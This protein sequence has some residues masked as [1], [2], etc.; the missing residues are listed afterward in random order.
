[1][2]ISYIYSVRK[3]KYQIYCTVPYKL[4]FFLATS[5]LPTSLVLRQSTQPE[6]DKP[7]HLIALQNPLSSASRLYLIPSQLITSPQSWYSQFCKRSHLLRTRTCFN[8]SPL[9][10]YGNMTSLCFKTPAL[11]PLFVDSCV[12][13][14]LKEKCRLVV[15][16]CKL[17]PVSVCRAPL[18]RTFPLVSS[19]LDI[20]DNSPLATNTTLL[21][22]TSYKETPL[23]PQASFC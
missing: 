20:Y 12:D 18:L 10:A 6:A 22:N 17:L 7:H 8:K 4:P 2:Y 14:V 13:T 23:P 21:D 15:A 9:T 16:V 3:Q 11:W 5:T 1:M 19:G